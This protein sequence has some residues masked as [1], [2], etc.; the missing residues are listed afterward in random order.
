[1]SIPEV[2]ATTGE[3]VHDWRP[4]LGVAA[5]ETCPIVE[6]VDRNEED[7]RTFGLSDGL[8]PSRDD[9]DSSQQ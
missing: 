8:R 2:D 3:P 1:M 9:G 6:V 4:G 5:Q 7:V